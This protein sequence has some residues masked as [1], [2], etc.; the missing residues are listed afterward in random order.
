MSQCTLHARSIAVHVRMHDRVSDDVGKKTFYQWVKSNIYV[1]RT[2]VERNKCQQPKSL[3]I[4]QTQT[5]NHRQKSRSASVKSSRRGLRASS[6]LFSFIIR[7]VS[8][9]LQ[10]R[11]TCRWYSTPAN[12]RASF[13]D[14]LIYSCTFPLLQTDTEK[15]QTAE[16][17]SLVFIWK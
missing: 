10:V 7:T 17:L 11:T 3:S 6:R 9:F 14:L 15:L 4:K 5:L 12:Y 8:V 1:V 13:K 2:D 16:M